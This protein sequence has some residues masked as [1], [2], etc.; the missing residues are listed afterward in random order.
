MSTTKKGQ[1]EKRT[2]IG[3]RGKL[4]FSF[5]AVAFT[6][7]VASTIGYYSI[8]KIEQSIDNITNDSVPS[9][10]KAMTLAQTSGSLESSMPLLSRVESDAEREFVLGGLQERVNQM[11]ELA[12]GL[13]TDS[14]LQERVEQVGKGVQTLDQLT[15]E[16][17]DSSYKLNQSMIELSSVQE[18]FDSNIATVIESANANFNA[19]TVEISHGSATTVSDLVDE[20]L[21]DLIRSLDLK[22]QVSN[23]LVNYSVAT[24]STDKGKLGVLRDK[25]RDIV[26]E[27]EENFED[28]MEDR[29]KGNLFLTMTIESFFD[30]ATGRPNIFELKEL[31]LDNPPDASDRSQA[32]STKMIRSSLKRFEKVNAEMDKVINKIRKEITSAA[33]LVEIN[34]RVTVPKLMSTGINKLR[35]LLEVRANSNILYGVLSETF[36]ISSIELVQSLEE[37]YAKIVENING[38]TE[39]LNSIK[40][41]GD[42]LR[43]NLALFLSYGTGETSIF[44]LKK[45]EL[46]SF[47][48]T[49][50]E[51]SNQKEILKDVLASINARVDLSKQSVSEASDTSASTIEQ[52]KLLLGAIVAASLLV[53]TLIV[54]LLVSRNIVARLL[55]VVTVLRSVSQGDLNCSIEATGNDELSMLARTVDVF[56]EKALENE[57]LQ[58]AEK[59]AEEER[60]LQQEANERRDHEIQEAREQKIKEEQLQAEREREQA[61]ALE[62]DTDSLLSVVRAASTGDLT[63]EV[64]VHGQH[65]AGQLG[66]GLET[67][68]NSF[69]NIMNQITQSV[70]FVS[71]GSHEIAEGNTQLAERT[72][73]Q[74]ENLKETSDSMEKMTESVRQN[75]ENAQKANELADRAQNQ[76]E[77]GSE[78]VTEAVKAMQVINESSLKIKDIVSVIDE[79]AFQT[80]LLALNAAVEAAR[81]GEQGRGFAVVATEVR[82]LAARSATAAKEIKDLIEDSVTKVDHGVKL[83]GES[84]VT[85]DELLGAVRNVTSIVG[86]IVVAS[87]NQTLKI[88]QVNDAVSTMEKMTQQNA[89]LVKEVA[90]ASDSMTGQ[91]VR[92]GEHVSF[93]NFKAEE[94]SEDYSENADTEVWDELDSDGPSDEDDWSDEQQ[95]LSA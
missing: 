34:T 38:S 52:S 12:K 68:I 64:V 3:V 61:E 91:S 54:W 51:V 93:F 33:S 50:S 63:R 87:E 46:R 49:D 8:N 19:E 10:N 45:A 84:G 76:A 23:L 80:N 47:E 56:R 44:E 73:L 1:G 24:N 79:I 29:I 77:Q 22:A 27:A 89:A 2:I 62:R 48:R 71:S 37:E 20:S 57:R 59:G 17:I 92:L 18:A 14:K 82:N 55:S 26:V 6:T 28:L 74:A 13:G 53:T 81:A 4:L 11:N 40:D 65:P 32:K 36:Q 60:K 41:G 90:S 30:K 94:P 58:E 35:Q 69:S 9:M 75:T 42:E 78:V 16:R 7:V 95:K 88:S 15:K 5:I 21:G 39:V 83:V 43:A 70:E 67:L 25:A 85:L 72:Q 31:E 66:D 86:D